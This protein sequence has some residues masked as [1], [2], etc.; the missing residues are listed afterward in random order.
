MLVKKFV[1]LLIPLFLSPRLSFAETE[2]DMDMEYLDAIDVVTD[3]KEKKFVDELP[4]S[5][6]VFTMTKLERNN[7]SSS[8]DVAAYVP[9]FHLPDYGSQMT[10]SVYV[11]GFGAR[12][13]QPVVGVVVDNVPILNKNAF[14]MDLFDLQ[15]M[16]FLRGPQGTLYGR[17]TMCGLLNLSTLSPFSYQGTRFSADY[18]T[19]NTVRLKASTYHKSSERFALSL[20]A[21]F[22][23]T[24]GL[25]KNLC[26]DEWCDPSNG[27]TFRNR[28]MWRP[29]DRLSF[30]N[31]LSL[32]V[33]RQGGYAY[34]RVTEDKRLPVAY[35]DECR[36]DRFNLSDGFVLTR[37]AE[38]WEFSS[39]SSYQCLD[40]DMLLDQDFSPASVFTLNQK[41]REHAATEELVFQSAGKDRRWNWK[42]GA[43]VFLKHN[44]MEAP[45]TFKR[46]G[47]EQLILANANEGISH[48]LP[49]DRLDVRENQFVV[50]SE[51]D[52]PTYGWA[53]YHQSEFNFGKW[54]FTLG[55]RLDYE[56]T[57]I[58]YDNGAKLNY[59][60]TAFME[61][62]KPLQSRME[63]SMTKSF[64]EVLPKVS[65]LYNINSR[66][67]V[68]AY[69]AKGYKAGGFNTQIFSD[70]LQNAL[71]NDMMGDMGMHFDDLGVANYDPQKAISY[72]PEYCWTYE[73]GGHFRTLDKSFS[74]DVALFYID[75]RDQQ[76]TVFPAGK[77][78]GRL[79]ANAGKSR[80]FGVEISLGYKVSAWDFSA[81]YGYTN[82][83]F[84]EFNDG[85]ASYDGNYVPFSPMNTVSSQISYTINVNRKLL[86]NMTLSVDWKGTGKI[87]WD[88]ANLKEQPFYSLFGASLS[89]HKKRFSWT[90]WGKNLGDAEYDTFY[91][92]SMGNSFCQLG[93][94]RRLGLSLNYEF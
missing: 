92:V 34:A 61:D 78:T 9:N 5:A 73:A 87:Y 91:F 67:N 23:H 70:I 62:Y 74:T 47:I 2:E 53:A 64:F 59:L 75:A 10:S 22:I 65:V 44:D 38:R 46:S 68:Y 21:N 81:S 37:K 51:F 40:D 13:E 11:R 60:F 14:D 80:S 43:F 29:N 16:E 86:D 69:A 94:P 49:D 72:D 36:Y 66:N 52:L 28:L 33:L 8:K 45:V 24:D 84:V 71:M 1:I 31:A 57:R 48:V 76:L 42:S 90:L 25:F 20:A 77:N 19:G 12:I 89:F 41:Q 93:K 50:E 82:A 35:N 26:T 55:L 85:H 63:G 56:K 83:K 54:T 3:V 18:S 17:N 32:G 7:V 58:E 27:L 6:N 39:V 30:E 15:R 79:M 4:V 88:E